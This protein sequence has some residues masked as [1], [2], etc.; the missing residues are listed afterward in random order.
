[1][2]AAP[3]VP[4][5]DLLP[6]E[7]LPSPS[8]FGH[9]GAV[10]PA[11]RH[12][13]R[14]RRTP[15]VTSTCPRSAR[16]KLR[17][18]G[19]LQSALRSMPLNKVCP[20][21]CISRQRYAYSSP[22]TKEIYRQTRP[23][24]PS[25]GRKLRSSWKVKQAVNIQTSCIF[26]PTL[27]RTAR[28]ASQPSHWTLRRMLPPKSRYMIPLPAFFSRRRQE[29]SQN[30]LRYDARSRMSPLNRFQKNNSAR[31]SHCVDSQPKDDDD[32]DLT[33]KRSSQLAGNANAKC[34]PFPLPPIPFEDYL[35]PQTE[36]IPP[37]VW[38]HPRIPSPGHP[39]TL[40]TAVAQHSQKVRREPCLSAVCRKGYPE[41]TSRCQRTHTQTHE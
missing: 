27:R 10:R 24:N 2:S 5:G 30:I 26:S 21:P 7:T 41:F 20:I 32:D 23:M 4:S 15:A 6:S 25:Y 34:K 37:P 16:F 17:W 36:V 39:N 38:P 9:T 3:Q 8:V 12:R 13:L 18:S 11:D 33:P 40:S 19:T 1:M 22:Q 29:C 31:T 28:Y 14:T 35:V